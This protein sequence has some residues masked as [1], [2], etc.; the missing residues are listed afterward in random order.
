MIN[1]AYAMDQGASGFSAFIPLIVMC[2]LLYLL[3]IRPLRKKI[4]QHNDMINNLK[5]EGNG[6]RNIQKKGMTM[7]LTKCP[8]CSQSVST[9]AIS[10]PHC[11]YPLRTDVTR[12]QKAAQKSAFVTDLQRETYRTEKNVEATVNLIFW[13]GLGISAFL[14]V[15][16]GLSFRKA[17]TVFA[18]GFFAAMII[19][20][21]IVTAKRKELREQ[22]EKRDNAVEE[23]VGQ[24]KWY[25]KHTKERNDNGTDE[26]P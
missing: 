9:E 20:W 12:V 11:G 14:F 25:G 8:E 15:S 2:V 10:C 24:R 23:I 6:T 13:I 21:L 26:M 18:V 7:A 22:R 4:K 1:I 5:A 16:G 3:I 17:Y 19:G